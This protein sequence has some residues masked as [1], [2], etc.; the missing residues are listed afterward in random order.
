MGTDQPADSKRFVQRKVEVDP[1][2]K[3]VKI[4]RKMGAWDYEP[5][6]TMDLSAFLDSQWKEAVHTGWAERRFG[7]SEDAR[8]TRKGRDLEIQIPVKFPKL[9][10]RMVGQGGKL[11]VSGNQRVGFSGKS[12]W[13]EGDVPTATSRASKFPSLNMEQKS[14]FTIEGTVGEKVHVQVDRDSE[15]LSEMENSLKIRYDGEEDEIIQ[16]IEAGNTT[17]SLPSTRFVGFSTQHKGLFGIRT[18]AKIGGLDV[19][20]IASQEKG[21]TAKKTF[22][23][24]AEESS[25]DI[26]DYE[27]VRNTYFFLDERYKNQYDPDKNPRDPGNI[28]RYDPAD[29]VVSI[30]VYVDDGN[31]NNDVELQAQSGWAFYYRMDDY[32]PDDPEAVFDPT[33]SGRYEQ[34]FFHPMDMS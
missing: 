29:S 2:T 10:Q 7:S 22:K 6:Y 23:G 3:R 20:A 13:T 19:V 9:M 4:S 27:Y 12:Q 18:K 30:E 31:V 32:N 34:G 28:I 11:A 25:N 15:R 33:T 1:E 16:E 5:A 26:R 21:A 17:L 14:R 8:D 24:M